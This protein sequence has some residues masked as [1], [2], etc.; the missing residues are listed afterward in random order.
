M[1]FAVLWDEAGNGK[2]SVFSN[3]LS[4]IRCFECTQYPKSGRVS[5]LEGIS[6]PGSVESWSSTQLPYCERFVHPQSMFFW[7]SWIF[8]HCWV[9]IGWLVTNCRSPVTATL[10]ASQRGIA[11]RPSLS[12]IAKAHWYSILDGFPTGSLNLNALKAPCITQHTS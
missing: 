2:T 6:Q 11:R 3:P 8:I 5:Y 12:S 7:C 4:K 1:V 10:T 9:H